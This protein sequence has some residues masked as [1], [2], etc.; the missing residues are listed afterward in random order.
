MI[1]LSVSLK[2]YLQDKFTHYKK[3]NFKVDD[4]TPSS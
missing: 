3:T 2:K 1:I 4:D